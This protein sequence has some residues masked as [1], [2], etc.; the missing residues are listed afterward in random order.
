MALQR[1]QQGDQHRKPY[2]YFTYHGGFN[3]T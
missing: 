3:Y 1:Q 2:A